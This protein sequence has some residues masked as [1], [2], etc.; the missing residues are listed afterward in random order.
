MEHHFDIDIARELG[1][2]EAIILNNLWFWV[3]KN[4][5][6]EMHFHD[7]EY[8]TYNSIKAM[9]SLHPYLTEKKIRN[10][11][12][13]LKS[14]G[15]LLIGN[16]N[17]SPYDRTTWYAFTQK[18]KSIMT[19]GQ[20]DMPIGQMEVTQ[21]ENGN[22]QK[23]E[24]IPYINPDGKA[25]DKNP[26]I[27]KQS[28][29]HEFETLWSIYPRK[30]GKQNAYRAYEK[31]RKEGIDYEDVKKG[32]EAYAEYTKGKDPRYIKMGSSFF[33]QRAWQDDWSVKSGHTGFDEYDSGSGTSDED[34]FGSGWN[35][36]FGT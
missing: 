24:P 6:N 26:Q 2:T 20:I 28:I 12:N 36:I 17:K 29:V 27:E 3:K 8:W 11:I 9:E 5:A 1:L 7:G 31:A 19:K 22:A 4:E 15:I 35:N 16:Y 21:K 23:G 13:R 32:I 33:S 18:G 34:F 25:L 10:A 30:Q 14:E